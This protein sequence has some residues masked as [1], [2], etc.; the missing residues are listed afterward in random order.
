MPS[1][2]VKAL[3]SS[4]PVPM[5]CV[6]PLKVCD[7]AV[8]PASTSIPMLAAAE[9]MARISSLVRPA[10]LPAAAKR[11]ASS[12]ICD[13]VEAPALPNATSESAKSS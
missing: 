3:T 8:P 9:L 10:E 2:S 12:T 1:V 7:S 13:S 11:A 4:D 6:M 5:A